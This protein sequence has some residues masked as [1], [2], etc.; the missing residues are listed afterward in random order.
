[1]VSRPRHRGRSGAPRRLGYAGPELAEPRVP[2]LG[3]G[4]VHAE[5]G[6]RRRLEERERRSEVAVVHGASM[7]GLVGEDQLGT[8]VANPV[9][10]RPRSL[11]DRP[12][13]P[14]VPLEHPPARP[15]RAQQH[16]EEPW[17]E[18][19][20]PQPYLRRPGGDART[21]IVE[22]AKRAASG[23]PHVE[24]PAEVVPQR[25][26]VS[27]E[28]R[29]V[30]S[31]VRAHDIQ[32]N[33]S[34]APPPEIHHRLGNPSK[35]AAASLGVEGA[36]GPHSRWNSRSSGSSGSRRRRRAKPA[37]RIDCPSALAAS[38]TA[39]AALP[40][41][42]SRIGLTSTSSSE[43]MTPDSARSARTRGAP[44]GR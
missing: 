27:P 44:R 40:F 7:P 19:M 17:R 29:D 15:T 26:Q 5:P 11:V 16:V 18:R 25:S 31:L 20:L 4:E 35:S 6:A 30:T 43:P 28:D 33:A 39:I 24:A 10:G 3:G 12:P 14:V 36:H 42:R 2:R 1:M 9:R 23:R 32:V 8:Q 34:I 13:D 37:Y 38:S 21:L 41:S 22:R